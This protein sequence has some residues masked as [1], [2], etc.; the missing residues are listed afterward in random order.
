ME[1]TNHPKSKAGRKAIH[2]SPAAR[3]AAYRARKAEKITA[4]LAHVAEPDTTA[5]DTLQKQL[6]EAKVQLRL[7]QSM[8]DTERGLAHLHDRERLKLQKEKVSLP[9]TKRSEASARVAVLRTYFVGSWP[10]VDD[11]KRLRVNTKK[12]AGAATELLGVLKNAGYDAQQSIAGDIEA[13]ESAIKLLADYG[14]SIEEMQHSAEAKKSQ[15]INEQKKEHEA[16]VK[17]VIAE[18]FPDPATMKRDVTKMAEDLI[19]YDKDGDAWL[20]SKK[21]T[22]RG[23]AHI[24]KG[25]DLRHALKTNDVA[26]LARLIAEEKIG[27]PLRG[28]SFKGYNEEVVWIGCWADFEAWRAITVDQRD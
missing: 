28:N 2:V 7:T 21:R 11:A 6:D 27:M 12:A 8:L 14:D 25:F 5:L 9:K 20:A 3:A 4:A 19:L 1:L 15:R 22:E 16:K 24:E 26:L 13:L 23:N 18:L 17:L 10:R